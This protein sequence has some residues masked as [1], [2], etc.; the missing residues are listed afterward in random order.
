MRRAKEIW[1]D[2][3]WQLLADDRLDGNDVY[4][5]V[6][7]GRVRLTGSVPS[8]PEKLAATADAWSVADVTDV[9][10][11]IR[12]RRRGARGPTDRDIAITAEAA[13]DVHPDLELAD[14]DVSV[15]AGEVTLA[16][17][18]DAYWKRD[19]AT[20]VVASVRGVVDIH[21]ELIV[22][23]FRDVGDEEI[24][25]RVMADIHRSPDVSENDV[26]VSVQN[27]VVVL[28]GT[29]SNRAA[30]RAAHEIACRIPGVRDVRDDI[31]VPR[32]LD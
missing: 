2:V 24:G 12:V 25:R 27:G 18:V 31:S 13:I 1:E 6:D 8:Y 26:E 28:T 23:P 22:E 4:V 20:E 5:E 10:N 9:D 15:D 3:A 17:T 29:V 21:N 7:R 32:P 19:V 30:R 14:I 16:G 11:E